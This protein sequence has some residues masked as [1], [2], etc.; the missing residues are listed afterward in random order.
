MT[1]SV[2]GFSAPKAAVILTIATIRIRP[3]PAIRQRQLC[4]SSIS[5]YFLS[6][7]RPSLRAVVL[8]GQQSM[9]GRAGTE[10]R[11]ILEAHPQD[12]QLFCIRIPAFSCLCSGFNSRLN[13]LGAFFSM[14]L[15]NPNL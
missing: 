3:Y 6:V 13:S 11:S 15:I 12:I 9:V 7:S 4:G 1:R 8:S 5:T 14:A 2:N 10:P